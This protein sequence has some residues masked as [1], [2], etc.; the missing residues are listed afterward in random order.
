MEMTGGCDEGILV[1]SMLPPAALQG[2]NLAVKST[3]AA[4][5]VRLQPN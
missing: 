4:E 3:G 2:G 5:P 1:T